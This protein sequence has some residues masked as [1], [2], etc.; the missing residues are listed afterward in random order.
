MA[1]KYFVRISFVTV[2]VYYCGKWIELK[3][4]FKQNYIVNPSQAALAY[5]IQGHKNKYNQS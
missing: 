4:I 1:S 5:P 2:N 3:H